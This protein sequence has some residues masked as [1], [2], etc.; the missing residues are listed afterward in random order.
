MLR[1][2]VFVFLLVLC[3]VWLHAEVYSKRDS[4]HRMNRD[5]FLVHEVSVVS[6]VSG[7]FSSGSVIQD[8]SAM[9][10]L[11]GETGNLTNLI[12]RYS[13]VYIKSDAGGLST[14]R[15]RGTS[16]NHTSLF[17][18]GLDINS[19]T[20]G[21]SNFSSIPVYLFDN[22]S[23]QYGGNSAENGSGSIG[24][25]IRL[26][27]RSQWTNGYQFETLG[28]IGSFGESLCGFKF[29]VGN[30][31]WEAAT[32]AYNYY[33]RNDF[34]FW[35]VAYRNFESS[36]PYQRDVQRYASVHTQAVLQ[37]LKYRFNADQYMSAML[38]AETNWHQAQPTMSANMGE[39]LSAYVLKE[40]NL[41]FWSVYHSKIGKV[42]YHIGVGG[43]KDNLIDFADETHSIGTQ[44]FVTEL[45]AE[46][47]FTNDAGYKIGAKYKYIVPHV[48]A[49]D[50]GINEQHLD[51][52]ASVYKS[53][54]HRLKLSL[55]MRQMFVT[56][57]SAPFTPA[58]GAEYLVLN[59]SHSYLKLL[60]NTSYSY[61]I[62]TFNDRFWSQPGYTGN[63]LLNPE[64][65]KNY[66]GGARY[67][68]CSARVAFNMSAHYFHHDVNNWLMWVNRTGGWHAENVL[69]VISKGL[70][71]K[72]D[73]TFSLR[74][75]VAKSGINYTYNTAMRKAST[76]T[77]DK[78]NQQLEYVPIHNGTMWLDVN[79]KAY[80]VSCDGNYTGQRY[81]DQIGGKL[82]AYTLINASAYG[83]YT[84]AKHTFKVVFS[85]DN[86]F[87]KSYQN[88]FFYAMP[89]RSYRVS[90][91]YMLDGN[92]D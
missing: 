75:V 55:N 36:N 66:E 21:H 76:S 69:R 40:K 83:K 25:S 72:T 73:V 13:P 14:I 87:A 91:K 28:S 1:P 34:P 85:V 16:P 61:R 19:L 88:Q 81:Y 22:I 3:S 51:V 82:D 44:R 77:T 84:L 52:Y 31:K 7:K 38:W 86:V 39:N 80:G 37:E 56:K 79:Y 20:L 68:Y 58:L 35:N 92:K 8:F 12:S 65:G 15:V 71:F 23:L 64:E 4:I 26:G 5:T 48:Y 10:M 78:I 54:F 50:E 41:R 62:P 17:F 70:E 63:A 11:V 29:F 67:A 59:L 9:Q 30:G 42:K 53:F 2:V 57:Y 32:R 6:T 24:G 46:Q 43:E 60:G 33:R 89:E 74:D 90:V 45:E 27:L 47:K 18:G 49:Y